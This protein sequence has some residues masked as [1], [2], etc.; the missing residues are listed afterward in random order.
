[1]ENARYS[2]GFKSQENECTDVRLQLSGTLPHWLAGTLIR[3]GPAKFEV[4]KDQYRHWF[5]G[6]AMLHKFEIKNQQASYSCKFLE[7]EVYKD[8]MKKNRIVHG[9]FGTDPCR[10]L[11]QKVFSFFKGPSPTDNGCVNVIQYGDT[12]TSCTE[13]Q[14]PKKFDLDSLETKGIF[15]FDDALKGQ[16]T[17]AHP[18]VDE[19]GNLYSYLT[20]VGYKSYYHIYRA[21]AGS[22]QR[23]LIA[24]IP[25]KEF[26][27]IHSFGM[28]HNY[29]IFMEYPLVALPLK[30]RFMDKPFIEKFSWKEERGTLIHLVNKTSGEVSTI[31]T[32]AFFCFHHINAFEEKGEI[33]FDLIT[34]EDASIVYHLYLEKLRTRDPFLAA[35]KLWRFSIPASKDRVDKR[36]LTDLPVELPRINC[37]AKKLAMKTKGDMLCYLRPG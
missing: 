35:G 18:H 3:T 2:Y 21:P 16:M 31:R 20:E 25:T 37:R 19:E 14:N 6:L 29:V 27:Y 24:S 11:F 34:Y 1:M 8:A 10:D 7:S 33:I 22:L 30:F 9:E 17:S 4:G 13:T 32:D 36:Q 28:T 12:L 5:D 15:K 23:E 26:A